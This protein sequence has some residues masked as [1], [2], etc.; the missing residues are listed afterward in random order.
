MSVKIHREGY[1]RIVIDDEPVRE[2][3]DLT[4]MEL[5]RLSTGNDEYVAQA[6]MAELRL[7]NGYTWPEDSARP[8]PVRQAAA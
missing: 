4:D 5:L 7:R 6:A 3:T 2:L 8:I 1:S